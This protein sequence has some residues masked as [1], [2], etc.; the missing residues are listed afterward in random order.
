MLDGS[1]GN[2]QQRFVRLGAIGLRRS[3]PG[4]R[5]CTFPVLPLHPL[6]RDSIH[7][8]AQICLIVVAQSLSNCGPS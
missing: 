8:G 7:K 2:M 5:Q 3:Q 1:A 6:R 4:R